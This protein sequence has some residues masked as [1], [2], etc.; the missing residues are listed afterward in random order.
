MELLMELPME[1]PMELPPI[2]I[3]LAPGND[4]R[5]DAMAQIDK[6][7]DAIRGLS[8]SDVSLLV[9]ILIDVVDSSTRWLSFAEKSTTA[10]LDLTIPISDDKTVSVA[11]SVTV[12][13]T[14]D[15][16]VWIPDE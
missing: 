16:F 13:N 4:V 2:R 6:Y 12:D 8:P 5:I 15:D 14:P 1:P 7:V 3:R 10:R 9:D 11:I